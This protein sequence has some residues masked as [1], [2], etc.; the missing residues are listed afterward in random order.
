LWVCAFG[1]VYWN[2]VGVILNAHI[3]P[4]C[5]FVTLNV[6]VYG[7]YVSYLQW[8]KNRL[9]VEFLKEQ[10]RMVCD[11]FQDIQEKFNGGF[12]VIEENGKVFMCGLK[13]FSLISYDSIH[14]INRDLYVVFPFPLDTKDGECFFEVSSSYLSNPLFPKIILNEIE[15]LRFSRFHPD[16]YE[17][18]WLHDEHVPPSKQFVLLFESCKKENLNKKPVRLPY[19]NDYLKVG[20]LVDIYDGFNKAVSDWFLDNKI[21]ESV[22]NN[23]KRHN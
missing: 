19:R 3:I 7:F 17:K 12:E 18:F 4:I 1:V 21:S 5:V 13:R 14:D 22:S 20:D 2:G 15:R 10:F 11:F 23:S 8:E 16:Y 6:T 9:E